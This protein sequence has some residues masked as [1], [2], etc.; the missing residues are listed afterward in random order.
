[1]EESTDSREKQVKKVLIITLVLNLLVAVVKIWAGKKFNYLSLSTS[2]L[3]S[4]FDGSSNILALISIYLAYQPADD[5]HSFGHYKYETLGSFV[6]GLLLIFSAFQINLDFNAIWE[7]K[8][9]HATFSWIPIIAIIS[10]MA[11]SLFVTI[12][13]RRKS[14][15][16]GSVVLEADAEHTFGDFIISFGV[17]ISIILSYFGYIWPDVIIGAV[18]ALYLLFLAYKIFRANLPDLLDA[19]PEI[20]S[21]LIKSIEDIKEVRD[22]HRFR[23]R[24]NKSYM[25]IDFH[26]HLDADLSLIEAHKIGH[27]AEEKLRKLLQNYSKV[28]DILVHIEPFDE[29]HKHLGE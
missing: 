21:H 26:L 6:I 22:I 10:S 15:E 24:G 12:Y 13:E 1:M 19:S 17:L 3:E 9:V 11:V 23:V 18:I 29:S 5:G 4:L 28:I 14:I 2:G 16:L 27:N 7:K 20:Q 25:H 8:E